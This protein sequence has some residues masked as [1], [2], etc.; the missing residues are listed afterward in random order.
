MAAM[1]MEITYLSNEAAVSA[2]EKRFQQTVELL[3]R[4]HYAIVIAN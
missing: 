4:A 3:F 2:E 1:N